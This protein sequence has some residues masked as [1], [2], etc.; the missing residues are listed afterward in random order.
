MTEAEPRRAAILPHRYAMTPVGEMRP[1]PSN[2]NRGDVDAIAES[3]EGI[4]F[5]GVVVVHEATGHILIGEHRWSAAQTVGLGELPAIVVDCDEDTARRIM[6]GDNEYAKLARW[7]VEALVGLLTEMR[8]S[9]AQLAATGFGE[10]RFAEL[11][12]QLH[13]APPDQFPGY[14]DDLPT[15]HKCPRCGYEWSGQT[16]PGTGAA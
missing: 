11:V 4:G 6:V 14:D 10:A 2:P 15:Q 7:D 16:R 12:A 5:Y 9:P 13:P 3:I 1:H 8:A